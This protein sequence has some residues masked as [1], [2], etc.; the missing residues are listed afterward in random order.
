M[1]KIRKVTFPLLLIIWVLGILFGSLLSVC[2]AQL[3]VNVA[4]MALSKT[5]A[6]IGVLIA[7]ALPFAILVMIL[8]RRMVM[9]VYPLIL[10]EALSR[11]FCGMS[12]ICFLGS[13]AWVL[14]FLFL[15]SPGC[16]SVLFWYMLYDY[17]QGVA[18][19]TFRDVCILSS[20]L[21]AVTFVDYFAISPFLVKLSE[22]F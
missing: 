9:L 8:S 19:R 4:R 3:S 10:L 22:Y 17:S 12:I 14:R 15:F 1:A 16:I 13:G 21:F 2:N 6:L 18:H 11:G 7:N 20:F 5:P